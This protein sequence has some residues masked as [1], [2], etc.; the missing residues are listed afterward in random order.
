M[1]CGAFT[2]C[3]HTE[4]WQEI[5]KDLAASDEIVLEQWRRR[6]LDLRLKEAFARLWAYWL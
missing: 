5:N 3:Q 6:S 1:L 4:Q 2:V